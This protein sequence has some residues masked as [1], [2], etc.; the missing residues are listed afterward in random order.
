LHGRATLSADRC[1]LD[2]AAV[3]INS[4]CRD[5][6]AV[7][8]EHMVERTIRV[9]QDLLAFAAYVLEFRQQLL[10]IGGWQGK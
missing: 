5:D 8:E 4:H 7:W 6:T 2:D 9:D 3:P 10:E 1:H